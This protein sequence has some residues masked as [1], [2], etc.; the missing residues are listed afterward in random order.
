ML[1][2][3][4]GCRCEPT[5]ARRIRERLKGIG[6][7]TLSLWALTAVACAPS[8]Y[9]LHLTGE[10]VALSH[11]RTSARVRPN[12]AVPG[13]DPCPLVRWELWGAP[14]WLGGGELCPLGYVPIYGRLIDSSSRES[15]RDPDEEC[16]VPSWT[17]RPLP[18][19]CWEVVAH[20]RGR[21]GNRPVTLRL[22]ADREVR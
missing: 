5:R 6:Q 2:H 22:G 17:P 21:V 14:L 10:S 18:Q 20:V 3:C 4:P 1:L 7:V 8:P 13:V 9:V 19:G 12:P 11:A 16:D 15:D